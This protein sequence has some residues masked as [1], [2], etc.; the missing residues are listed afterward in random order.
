LKRVLFLTIGLLMVLG[1]VLPGCTGGGGGGGAP[2]ITIAVCGPMTDIQGTNMWTGAQ[3]AR[4]ELNSAGVIINGTSYTVA[5]VQVETKESTDG[6]TGSTGTANLNAALTNHNITF[7][8]GGFR[9]EVVSVYREVAMTAQKIFMNCGAATGTLQFSVIA[10]YTKYKYWFK[11]TPYNESF[12]VKS[13]LKM[14]KTIGAVLAGNLAV[15]DGLNLTKPDYRLDHS[16]GELRVE[17]LMENAAWCA[18]MVVAAQIYLPLLGFNVTGTTLVSPT[19]SN[20]NAEL[21]AIAAREPHIIFTAFS[22][23]VGAVY[24]IEKNALGIPAMT[25]GINVPGQLKD[26]YVDTGGTCLGEI[27]LDTWAENLSIAPGTV[28]WFNHYVGLTGN[29]PL[30][31][32]DTYDAIR[33]VV[34]TM[35]AVNSI[36]TNT[37][38]AALETGVMTDSVGAPKARV[39]PMPGYYVSGTLFALCETQVAALYPAFNMSLFSNTTW[40]AG[41]INTTQFPHIAHDLVYGPGYSTGIG[42]QWQNVSGAGKKVGIWPMYLGPSYD[43]PLTDQYGNWNFQYN[44]TM[45]VVIPISG[46][47]L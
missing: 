25:I 17:I 38:I 37:V 42:S 24:S 22:G 27:M 34:H 3:M 5:L 10:N 4:D 14:T 18:G 43:V 46:F 21:S 11:T 41:Y 28:S 16:Y 47:L 13:C 6:E 35:E 20:I 45:P 8:V 39:Y 19:A 32:A 26:H 7:C 9:T 12:L 1:L 44:G 33:N 2:T 40:G 15:T 31:T 23:S 29:Y 36:D 30:Y